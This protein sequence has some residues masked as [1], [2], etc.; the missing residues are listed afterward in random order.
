MQAMTDI[1]NSWLVRPTDVIAH[2]VYMA[3]T[4][5]PVVLS[6]PGFRVR[7]WFRSPG[8]A[9]VR[10]APMP[11]ETVTTLPPGTPIKADYAGARDEYTFYSRFCWV[12]DNGDWLVEAPRTVERTDR[13]LTERHRMD[14]VS[15]VTFCVTEWP[16]KPEMVVHDLSVGGLAVLH[17]APLRTLN[18]EELLDGELELPAEDPVPMCVEVR[19]ISELGGPRPINLVGLQITAIT[20]VD[21]E[22]LAGFLA[23]RLRDRV[24]Q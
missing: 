22:R 18:V 15:G 2:L 5:T 1:G 13:R 23:R 7:G 8:T 6:G 21:R 17:E 20:T 14:R 12:A 3:S 19:H 9:G 16:G 11:N 4:E 24:R 10:F